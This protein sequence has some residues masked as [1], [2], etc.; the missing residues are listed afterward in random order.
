MS[1]DIF[2]LA[3]FILLLV[4]GLAKLAVA[5]AREIKNPDHGPVDV[6]HEKPL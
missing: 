4:V 3:V 5:V 2:P 1:P 6:I